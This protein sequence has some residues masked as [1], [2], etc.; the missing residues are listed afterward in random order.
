MDY[1]KTLKIG[2][3]LTMLVNPPEGGLFVKAMNFHETRQVAPKPVPGA[4]A[5][6][7]MEMAEY[8]QVSER[9]AIL[10]LIREQEL[11]RELAKPLLEREE[12]IQSNKQDLTTQLLRKAL[13][14]GMIRDVEKLV[15]AV[16]TEESKARDTEAI[17]RRYESS[18]PPDLVRETFGNIQ[19]RATDSEARG[20]P[21]GRLESRVPRPRAT[22]SG[23]EAS[24]QSILAEK[25]K[26]GGALISEL[27]SVLGERAKRREEASSLTAFGDEP[28][29]ATFMLPQRPRAT[30]DATMLERLTAKSPAMGRGFAGEGESKEPEEEPAFRR[31]QPP[32]SSARPPPP[33]SPTE[34]T[35]PRADTLRFSQ[36]KRTLPPQ[37]SEEDIAPLSRSSKS[38]L[39]SA[40]EQV[41]LP[42]PTA[43]QLQKR[44]RK[45]KA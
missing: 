23:A 4:G 10:G 21:M 43:L 41:G 15:R 7:R 32:P 2:D 17:L 13:E 27:K 33:P 44:G 29:S 20:E 24:R 31:P 38:K 36:I 8:R 11:R 6:T 12:R 9:Q 16:G 30:R 39:R 34:T 19:Q 25:P 37:L 45:P 42:I 1:L 28:S 18:F 26:L 35:D 40:Y 5:F 22:Q 3:P 14:T